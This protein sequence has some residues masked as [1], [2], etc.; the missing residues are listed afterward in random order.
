[1]PVVKYVKYV[2]LHEKKTFKIAMK[3][4]YKMYKK[5]IDARTQWLV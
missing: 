2:S 4:T 1:M 3:N 5:R